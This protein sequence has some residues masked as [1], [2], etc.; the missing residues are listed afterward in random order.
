MDNDGLV[1]R[2]EPRR[3]QQRHRL[4]PRAQDAFK[5][6]TVGNYVGAGA[7]LT[8]NA[9]FG[10]NRLGR[11]TNSSSKAGARPGSTLITIHNVGGVGA[12]TTGN[13]IPLIAVANGGTTGPNAFALANTPCRRRVQVLAGRNQ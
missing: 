6:L 13:G 1:G 4:R 3:H 9:V 2:V 11:R 8:M 7:S 10:R 12:Q 5:T